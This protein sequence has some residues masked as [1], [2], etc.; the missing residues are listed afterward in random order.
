MPEPEPEPSEPEPSQTDRDI[1]KQLKLVTNSIPKDGIMD[2]VFSFIK[3][4]KP[5]KKGGYGEIERFKIVNEKECTIKISKAREFSDNQV[6]TDDRLISYPVIKGDKIHNICF[7]RSE[8]LS[9]ISDNDGKFTP[10]IMKELE[11]AMN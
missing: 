7:L 3:S 10:K 1:K 5:L 4:F 11:N 9:L 6:F 2:D 8:L